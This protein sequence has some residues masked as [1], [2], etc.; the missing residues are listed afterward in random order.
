VQV[1]R[2]IRNAQVKGFYE[3]MQEAS[4]GHFA[5]RQRIERY[6]L[7]GALERMPSVHI[8]M[9]RQGNTGMII[10]GC[11]RVSLGRAAGQQTLPLGGPICSPTFYVDGHRVSTDAF[12]D[13]MMSLPPEATEGV[14][15]H[16]AS[17]VPPQYGGSG[18]GGCGVLMLW[19][20]SLAGGGATGADSARTGG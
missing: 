20:H 13:M 9:C 4:G 18:I 16:E 3:R 5:G 12:V 11:Y 17:N 14:E 19:T 15:V 7:R 2:S 1:E 10:V 6:G 8:T